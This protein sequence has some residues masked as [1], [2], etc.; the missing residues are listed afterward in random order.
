MDD[1]HR[2][3]RECKLTDEIIL[4]T[5]IYIK[6]SMILLRDF[7]LSVPLPTHLLKIASFINERYYS[8]ISR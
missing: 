4:K 3:M 7:K 6:K 2:G 8:W 1:S 5:D